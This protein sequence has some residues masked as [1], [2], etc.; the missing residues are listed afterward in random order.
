MEQIEFC[1]HTNRSI[2]IQDIGWG[3]GVK[4]EIKKERKKENKKG[5]CDFCEK[6]IYLLLGALGGDKNN[7]LRST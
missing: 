1:R 7:S 3:W 6:G 4:R 2:K 5:C